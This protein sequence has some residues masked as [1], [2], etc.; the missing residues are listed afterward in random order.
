MALNDDFGDFNNNDVCAAGVPERHVGRH[1]PQ[2][3]GAGAHTAVVAASG[4][5]L[6]VPA[7]CMPMHFVGC[8]AATGFI[9]QRAL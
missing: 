6:F 4:K 8:H 3:H 9:M 5:W 7:R 2:P 1:P